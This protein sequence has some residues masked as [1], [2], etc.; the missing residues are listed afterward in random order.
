MK[1]ASVLSVEGKPVKEIAAPEFFSGRIREDI[2]QKCLEA[3]KSKQPYAPFYMAGLQASASGQ[4]KHAR[5]KWKTA[6]GKGISRI[7]RKIMW[8][9]GTQF[10]WIGATIPG[11][12]G[13]RKAHPPKIKS[14]LNKRKINK[15]ELRIAFLSAIA[16]T[17]D[18]DF[19]RK[20]YSSVSVEK[21]N[22]PFIVE[23]KITGLK[24]KEFVEAIKKILGNLYSVALQKKSVRAGKGKLR[25]RKYRRS[26]G[27]LLVIGDDENLRMK[28]IDIKKAGKLSIEDLAEG[29]PGRLSVYTEK[30]IEDLE[31]RIEGKNEDKERGKKEI[32]E[33]ERK[34][35]RK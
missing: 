33:E 27:M 26:A 17:A 10:F 28:G 31:K 16:A 34:K 32:K 22:A 15:K 12:R 30:A 9:R 3:R 2:V 8:R 14:M 5:R 20:R 11:T 19:I 13:G 25:G 21:F 6:Y 7:P 35:S 1:K 23:S 24:A 4:L 18:P 29:K